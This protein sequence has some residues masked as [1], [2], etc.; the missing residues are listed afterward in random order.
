VVDL[1][2][3]RQLKLYSFKAET[4]EE[5]HHPISVVPETLDRGLGQEGA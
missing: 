1:I 5:C 3:V 4:G 2:K